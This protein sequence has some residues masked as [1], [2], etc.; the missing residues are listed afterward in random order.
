M[1]VPFLCKIVFC[2]LFAKGQGSSID[3][4]KA[5]IAWLFPSH[6]KENCHSCCSRFRLSALTKHCSSSSSSSDSD[7]DWCNKF[8]DKQHHFMI[9]SVVEKDLFFHVFSHRVGVCSTIIVVWKDLQGLPFHLPNLIL[10]RSTFVLSK[11]QAA[12]STLLF[13][14]HPP[15]SLWEVKMQPHVKCLGTNTLLALF[16]AYWCWVP[17]LDTVRHRSLWGSLPWTWLTPAY[18]FLPRHL[19][20]HRVVESWRDWVPKEKCWTCI[21]QWNLASE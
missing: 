9:N 3:A 4:C 10:C 5:E 18:Q 19:G 2:Q 11:L 8:M 13:P 1:H 12:C 16:R 15:K 6:A 7:C 17:K 21:S 20:V 14:F